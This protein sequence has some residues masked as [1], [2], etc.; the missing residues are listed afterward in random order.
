MPLFGSITKIEAQVFNLLIS[1]TI[2][3]LMRKRY[4]CWVLLLAGCMP[5]AEET[6][7]IR[8]DV[9][10]TVFASGVLEADGTYSL[11]AQSD[12]YLSEVNFQENDIVS[13][14]DILAVVEN[15]QNE[16]N[17]ESAEAL[18]Q[19]AQNNAQPNS[20]ALMQAK[21][22]V[23]IA[24]SQMQLDSTQWV[25]Y[26]KLMAANSIAK[27]EYE[28]IKV[29]YEKSKKDWEN[30]QENYEQTKRQAKEQLIVNRSQKEINQVL[31][32]FNQIRAVK[33]GK[34]Y[35]KFKQAGDFV[36]KGDVIATVGD[37]H[38][39]YAKV[40][41]DEG[42]IQRVRVGQKAIVQLNTHLSQ[43][44]HGKVAEILPAFDANT[45]SFT[46]KI[47]FEDSLQFPVIQTQLQANIVIGETK[48]A[49]LIPRR[50]LQPGGKVLLK[51][52]PIPVLVETRSVSAEWVEVTNGLDENSVI[53]PPQ[54]AM[55]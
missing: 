17:R 8:Q 26:Q 49:L 39:L 18:Y 44:L 35:Q 14:G 20:P 41:V 3:K 46:C 4:A 47:F 48:N 24:Y 28:Q 15:R 7:P 30:A 6:T 25:R 32:G 51:D 33:G 22:S 13:P 16:L 52:N 9:V 19:L 42:N 5:Q 1:M 29:R 55:P 36:R 27:N 10:E 12:G 2:K 43:K 23:E 38:F 21:N 50:L 11:S 53:V 37:A 54:P 45:Q 34:V 31:S 40:R